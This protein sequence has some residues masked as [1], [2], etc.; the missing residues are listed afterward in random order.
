[1]AATDLHLNPTS[2]FGGRL[3]VPG[4]K[5]I[6]HRYVLLGSLAEGQ[7]TVTG[8]APGAD[9][10][11]SVACLQAL[12]AHIT[13]PAPDSVVIKGRG[14]HRLAPADGDL[15]CHNS[16]TTMRLLAG[17][18][19]S[20]PF[21]SRLTGDASLSRRPMRRVIEP[22]AAMGAEISAR[23]GRPP[24]EIIGGALHGID[25]TPPVASAQVKSAILLAGLAA[26]GITTVHEPLPTRD[27][28]ER[29]FGLFGIEHESRPGVTAVRGGQWPT[30][31]T[32]TLRVPGDPSSAAVWAAAAASR[33]GWSVEIDGVCLNPLRLGFVHA[34]SR[35][36]A[37]VRTTET[38][39]V[40]GEAVGTMVV[41]QGAPK[42]AVIEPS[43]VPSLIDE[44]P[45]LAA[46][47]ALGG[48]LRV[49]G[50][51]ELRVKESDRISAL[52][53]GFRRLG[54]RLTELPDGFEIEGGQRPSGGQADA[55]LDHRLVMAFT[56]LALSA[57]GPTH[58]TGA[59]AV[60]VSYPAFHADLVRL[61]E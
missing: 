12:G 6:S 25:W 56:V 14:R 20:H 8:L 60:A 42:L 24:I 11:A 3:A 49:T 9:V 29:A 43:L 58:I 31:P 23:D 10:A 22:L 55:H 28:T 36:G 13:R 44:L 51:A 17:I 57:T 1:M 39:R 46:T 48:G 34:L 16:G 30:A 32:A 59:N 15:N 61:T 21:R 41:T 27:H 45:V 38:G 19:A 5:S 37:S 18:V 40:G 7:T 50:A 47:A 2:R 26:E 35:M 54:V 33:P 4:D 52:A 53:D